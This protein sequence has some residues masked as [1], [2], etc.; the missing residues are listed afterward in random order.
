MGEPATDTERLIDDVEARNDSVAK[1]QLLDRCRAAAARQRRANDPTADAVHEFCDDARDAG[2][3]NTAAWDRLERE[4][5][6][7]RRRLGD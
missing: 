2:V 5:Q 1:Q 6:Q 3:T 4:W 7:L